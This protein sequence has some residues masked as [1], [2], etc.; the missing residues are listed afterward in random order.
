M[1]E[2]K[3]ATAE[4]KKPDG[5]YVVM[6][7][8]AVVLIAGLIGAGW[9][10]LSEESADD[11]AKQARFAFRQ[12]DY[13]T[14][15]DLAARAFAVQADND[16][17]L[18]AG[19]S[20]QKLGDLDGAM[21]WYR[22][23]TEED[24]E[25]FLSGAITHASLCNEEGRLTESEEWFRKALKLRP[26]NLGLNRAMGALLSVEGRRWEANQYFL[27]TLKLGAFTNQVTLNDALMLA[28]HEAPYVDEA[29]YEKAMA[30]VPEDPI[31]EL[32]LVQ[33]HFVYNRPAEAM[34]ILNAVIKKHP[35]LLQAHA[36]LG[37]CLTD[38]ERLDAVPEWN[39]NLPEGADDF[40][41][42]WQVRGIWAKRVGQPE[43]AARCIWKAIGLEPNSILSNQEL[44]L[45]LKALGRDADAEPFVSRHAKL[46][47]YNKTTH[48]I[49]R[50]GL[51]LDAVLRSLE[52]TTELGRP[53]ECYVWAGALVEMAQQ[54]RE[55]Q[56]VVQKG[57]TALQ[58]SQ[59]QLQA[60]PPQTFADANPAL[61]LD[62]SD[63][64]LPDWS[65]E[66]SQIPK[67]P[68]D[69]STDTSGIR[70]ED[71]AGELG[72]T[73][74]YKNNANRKTS[75]HRMFETTGGG[76][77]A[78]DFDLDG[79]P[80]LHFT[81][82]A[83]WPIDLDTAELSD[84]LYRSI[85]GQEFVDITK[86]AGL[87]DLNYGQGIAVSDIDNDGFPDIYVANIGRNRLFRNNGD[88]TFAEVQIADM[89]ERWTTSVLIADLNGD[90]LPD[91]FDANY[92]DGEDVFTKLCDSGEVQRACAPSAFASAQNDVYLNNGDGSFQVATE[93]VG[94]AGVKGKALGLVAADFDGTGR[95]NVFV[96]NDGIEN[97][98]WVPRGTGSEFRLNEVS[99]ERGVAFDQDARGQACMGIAIDD[100]DGTG[101]LDLFVTNY[102]DE[103]NTLY[104]LQPGQL[105][106]D[107]S[108]D[109]GLRDPSFRLLGFGTQ[110]LDAD[111]D[112]LPDLVLTN[113]HIDDFTHEDIPF[114]MRPQ[115]YRNIGGRFIEIKP[116]SDD[117]Y[118]NK[119]QLG[120]SLARLDFNRDGKPDFVVSHLDTPAAIVENQTAKPGHF[121]T[122]QLIGTTGSR[123]ASGA[124]VVVET[125]KR[126]RSVHL[127]AGGGYQAANENRL[128]VGLGDAEQ[129]NK[130]TVR[131]LSGDEQTFLDVP[132]DSEVVLIE[133]RE[134]VLTSVR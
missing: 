120:R 47:D 58:T 8:V 60:D 21:G 55:A 102:Y 12:G 10:F 61:Q 1:D 41:E 7:G 71:I 33:S 63:Y 62:L 134:E 57:I 9:Y 65:I 36:W 74:Q 30:A 70:F 3:D 97:H 132:I 81:Q 108:R 118:F 31:G 110:A 127:A 14:T 69:S 87:R 92:L 116:T 37:R 51:N 112:G 130:V 98:Y 113:G 114:R 68:G 49:L 38:L 123:D 107:Q 126:T 27:K 17:A 85:H 73:F 100:F 53:W 54:N 101:T 2:Q 133:G 117:V 4:E 94:V 83:N 56:A 72:V 125:P 35:S 119:K 52:L 28:N 11:L 45:A 93:T 106:Q 79:W 20:C 19:E 18:M 78:L 76:V 121:L 95:L 6:I 115:M 84:T 48:P 75:G 89:P 66:I 44:G 67:A 23:L 59:T 13:E 129:I 15:R 96:G 86:N 22:K 43:A 99:L 111:L 88:G 5:S 77:A 104:S 32:G 109:A 34:Q 91:L 64:P 122:V 26:D 82:G 29:L 90:G 39:S 131:W 40:P 80:D 24:T 128:N 103:S 50:N 42:I 16:I 46:V 105:F 25:E 124:T